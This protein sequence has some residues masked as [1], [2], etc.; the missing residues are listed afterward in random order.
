[1]ERA[2]YRRVSPSRYNPAS[3]G[4]GGG[5]K[6]KLI[7]QAI[8]SGLVLAFALTVSVFDSPLS[9]PVQNG[10]QRVF[11]GH[12]TADEL[13]SGIQQT[14]RRWFG[15]AEETVFIPPVILLPPEESAIHNS[16][17]LPVSYIN[18]SFLYD[19]SYPLTAVESESKS[20][21]P[22]LSFIPEP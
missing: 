2:H 5:V 10:L 15:T 3:P 16:S 7:T 22:E 14:T 6:E 18:D 4:E 19:A 17:P 8:V 12:T 9:A 21:V 20:T 13:L 11:E 1:M